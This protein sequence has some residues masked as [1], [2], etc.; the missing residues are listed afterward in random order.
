LRGKKDQLL[1]S[2]QKPSNITNC[3]V[4]ALAKLFE[5]NGQNISPEAIA[6]LCPDNGMVSL[7]DLKAAAEEKGLT[8]V[9]A[10]M[11]ARQLAKIETPVLAHVRPGHFVVVTDCTENEV[12]VLDPHAGHVDYARA[13]FQ[14]KWTG[15]V[16]VF[17]RQQA[18]DS[19]HPLSEKALHQIRGGHHLHGNNLGGPEHNPPV[20][21]D[22]GPS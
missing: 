6:D 1:A 16:L 5:L 19:P 14:K 12:E 17:A 20:M 13:R 4:L 18:I 21:F 7:G 2:A 22:P 9:A 8:L 15:Y 11:N 3:G 10:K